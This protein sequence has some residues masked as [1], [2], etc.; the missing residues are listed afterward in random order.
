MCRQGCRAC[1]RSVTSQ[2]IK[3]DIETLQSLDLAYHNV[4]PEA[5]LYYG[6]TQAGLM[7]TLVSDEEIEAARNAAPTQTRAALR[8][9]LVR[10]F[11]ENIK[12]LSWGVVH[13]EENGERFSIRLPKFAD[14]PTLA[15]RVENAE[16]LRDAVGALKS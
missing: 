13:A 12:S 14:F 8:G 16:T 2:C 5:G 7:Q 1:K 4:D 3:H 15:A 11:A 10:K 6:L 9:V